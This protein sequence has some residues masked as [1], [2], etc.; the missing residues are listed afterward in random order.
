MLNRKL[1]TSPNAPFF[2]LRKQAVDRATRYVQPVTRVASQIESRRSIAR[3]PPS[4]RPLN[5]EAEPC[6]FPAF[7]IPFWPVLYLFC[8]YVPGSWTS[9]ATATMGFL[10]ARGRGSHFLEH[11]AFP[12]WPPASLSR[13]AHTQMG[14]FHVF[15]TPARVARGPFTL[16]KKIMSYE[17]PYIR[18]S[19][20]TT[21]RKTVRKLREKSREN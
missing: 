6:Q 2:S 21:I 17:K 12:F 9:T 15:Q 14:Y 8:F 5:L 19:N 16:R 18:E 1:E 11:C 4:C 13:A 7:Q 20:E 3:C 10:S